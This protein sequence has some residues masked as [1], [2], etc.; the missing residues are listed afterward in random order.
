VAVVPGSAFGESGEG[1]VRC[2]FAT[3]LVKLQEAMNRIESYVKK[4]GA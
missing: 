3:S 1:F 4:L 2:C